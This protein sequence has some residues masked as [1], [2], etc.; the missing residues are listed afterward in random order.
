MNRLWVRLALAFALVI[1]VAVGAVAVLANLRAGEAFRLYLSFSSSAAFDPLVESLA[2]YY[3][4]NGTWQG[5]EAILNR[6]AA[7]SRGMPG[8]VRGLSFPGDSKPQVVLSDAHGHVL[9][10]RAGPG[11]DRPLS[12]D[13]E[14]AAQDILVDGELVGRLVVAWPMQSAILGP[15]EQRFFDRIRQFLVAGAVLAGGLG[16]LLGLALS[17]SLT[18]PLQ[19]LATAARALAAGDLSRRV[20]VGGGAE[21]ADVGQAFNEMAEGLEQAERLRQ[22]LVADVAHELRTPLSVLQGNLQ[23][24]LDDV[25]R[26]DKDEIS[27]LYDETRLLSRLVDDLRELALADAGQLRLNLLP[28][29]AAQVLRATCNHLSP[30]AEA[31]NVTLTIHA[32][33][34][35]PAVLADPDRVTQ[36]LHNLLVNALRHTPPGGSVAVTASHTDDAV[37]IAVVDTGEGI[38]PQDLPH[39]FDRFWRTDRSRSRDERWEGGSGLGLSIA[40][41]LVKAQGGRIWAESTPGQG[42][43]V[44]F[45]LPL[46]QER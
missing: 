16:V 35:L 27:R 26:L 28:T 25:Y 42:T 13:E 2:A 1:L 10:D 21:V 30:T 40:Q 44:G 36:I 3:Q 4:A 6:V 22:N 9:Y 7:P 20:E 43:T 11:P 29:D 8:R 34:D 24:I 33:G 12:R 15:L 5:V 23:A 37:Q 18:A 19:R 41:T 32:P 46:H 17:R 38:A 45:T 31:Q 39:V 14:A